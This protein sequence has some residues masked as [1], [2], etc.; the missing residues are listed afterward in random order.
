MPRIFLPKDWKDR[1]ARAVRNLNRR[2]VVGVGFWCGHGYR[3]YSPETETAYLLEC[4]EYPQEGKRRLRS[5]RRSPR[6]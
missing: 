2:G 1:A 4:P 3:E 5:V 6:A